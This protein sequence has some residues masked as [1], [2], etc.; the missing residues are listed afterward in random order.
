[1]AVIVLHHDSHNC[2]PSWWQLQYSIK[3]CRCLWPL[4]LQLAIIVIFTFAIMLAI[5]NHDC[6][7]RHNHDITQN[8]AEQVFHCD[9]GHDNSDRHHCCGEHFEASVRRRPWKGENDKCSI[10]LKALHACH[11]VFAFG[12]WVNK[13]D[14]YANVYISWSLYLLPAMVCE[15]SVDM[16]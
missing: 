15:N 9:G 2:A 13:S 8:L 6:W 12:E 3:Q 4:T 14:I 16:V 5:Y 11:F 10:I 7:H 1:M